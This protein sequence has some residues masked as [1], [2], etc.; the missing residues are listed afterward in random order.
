MRKLV[1]LILV[2]LSSILVISFFYNK[3]N[4]G[5]SAKVCF[6]NNLCLEAEIVST[7]EEKARGLMYRDGLEEG[8]GMLFP[9]DSESRHGFWMKNMR[10]PIDMIWISAD[11]KVV[12]VERS[13]PPCREDPCTI[14]RPSEPAKYVFETRANFTAE[15]GVDPGSEAEI[16]EF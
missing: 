10:F 3:N 4:E 9:F 15:N 16:P 12:H 1:I 14:Y 2:I 11:G 7:P 6:E 8:R 13:V 5:D